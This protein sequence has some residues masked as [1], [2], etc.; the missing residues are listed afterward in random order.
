MPRSAAVVAELRDRGLPAV[1]S[2][3]GP[4]VLV[5]ARG[6]TEAETAFSCV[7]DGWTARA[8]PVDTSGAQLLGE[9]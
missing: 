7:P 2:G 8:L 1:I 5:L 6:E 4:T 9:P 3:A